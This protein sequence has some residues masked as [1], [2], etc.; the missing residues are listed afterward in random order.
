MSNAVAPLLRSSAPLTKTHRRKRQITHRNAASSGIS[1]TLGKI[2]IESAHPVKRTSLGSQFDQTPGLS[3]GPSAP[4]SSPFVNHH[5]N[6]TPSPSLSL[7]H[8]S[9]HLSAP[10]KNI[11]CGNA[12]P[13]IA[14]YTPFSQNFNNEAKSDV[15]NIAPDSDSEMAGDGYMTTAEI[16]ENALRKQDKTRL[17]EQALMNG[18]PYAEEVRSLG[19]QQHRKEGY[20]AAEHR[21]VRKLVE[22]AEHGE[23]KKKQERAENMQR[24]AEEAAHREKKRT[25]EELY[26][27]GTMAPF[28]NKL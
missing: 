10:H 28:R 16:L 17:R 11:Q 26:A 20:H 14:S 24:K 2:G 8:H 21:Q 23:Q 5:I 12:K 7:D 22:Q 19:K 15:T 13:V 25:R 4:N 6:H 3:S 27:K 9:E 18:D 1:K